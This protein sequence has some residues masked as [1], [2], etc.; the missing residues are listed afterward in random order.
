MTILL[1]MVVVKRSGAPIA[2]EERPLVPS[3]SFS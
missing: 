3:E 2:I 1:F